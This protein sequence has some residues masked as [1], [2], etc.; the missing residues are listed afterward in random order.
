LVDNRANI[1]AL[2][3]VRT[4]EEIDM[5][6]FLVAATLTA[7]FLVPTA[8]RAGFLLEASLGKGGQV[9]PSPRA[10]EQMNLEIAP[11]YAPNLPVLS[12]VHLQLGIVADFADKSG[13]ST[14]MALR[15]MISLVP[16]V[17]PLYGRLILEVSNLLDKSD[18]KREISYGA[19]VGAMIGLPSIA[20]LPGFGVFAEVGALPR[21]RD[22]ADSGSATGISSKT[23]LIVEGRVGAYLKF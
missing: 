11:G 15:P 8:A 4:L 18:A 19:A 13:T 17:I 6:K 14:N 12:W 7:M 20:F 3:N 22:V 23:A 21:K 16:P 9:S 1:L 10:W 5:R 2:V